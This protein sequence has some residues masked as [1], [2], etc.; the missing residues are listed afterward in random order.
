[1]PT[2]AGQAWQNMKMI[3]LIPND[4]SPLFKKG[5]VDKKNLRGKSGI[6]FQLDMYT[7]N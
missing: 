7:S 5:K 6:A 3:P 2:H 1:M 4:N